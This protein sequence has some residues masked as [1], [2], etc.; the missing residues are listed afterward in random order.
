MPFPRRVLLLAC[1]L[2]ACDRSGHDVVVELRL[3]DAEGTLAPAAGQAVIALPYDRDSVMAA[4]EA[5]GGPRPHARTI[6]S[7]YDA[8]AIPYG[9][10]HEASTAAIVGMA[11]ASGVAEELFFRGTLLPWI[12]V[13]PSAIVFG[14][15]H[16]VRGPARWLWVGWATVMGL[17]LGALYRATGDLVGPV[18]AHVLVNL[19]NLLYLRDG[20]GLNDRDPIEPSRA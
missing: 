7:L 11:V 4:L 18:L 9:Q 19:F 8:F 16:Q 20:G 13:V 5:Q 17:L 10:V 15:V 2:A 3:P 1:L 12:G 6:D 14:L